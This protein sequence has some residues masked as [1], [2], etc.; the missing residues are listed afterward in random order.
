[1]KLG[2]EWIYSSGILTELL[3]NVKDFINKEIAE[4]I[5]YRRFI[6]FYI[7]STA[8]TTSSIDCTYEMPDAQVI[9][10]FNEHFRTP[11]IGVEETG[12]YEKTF[13]SIRK[14]DIDIRRFC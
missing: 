12:V 9:T 11:E 8:N 5:G 7:N 10:I 6:F 13:Q 4:H 3:N 1:M 2:V 14:T